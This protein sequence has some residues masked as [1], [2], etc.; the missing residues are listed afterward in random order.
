MVRVTSNFVGNAL[1]SIL[2]EQIAPEGA[3]ASSLADQ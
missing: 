1:P 3:P 2:I